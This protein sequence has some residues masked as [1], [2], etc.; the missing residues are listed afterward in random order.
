MCCSVFSEGGEV[1]PVPRGVTD[2]DVE[3]AYPASSGLQVRDPF[4]KILTWI[5]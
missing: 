1:L 2:A 3:D 5:T 4:C